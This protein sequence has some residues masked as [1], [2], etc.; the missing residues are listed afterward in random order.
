MCIFEVRLIGLI[1]Q[2]VDKSAAE[3]ADRLDKKF[4]A[5]P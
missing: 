1:V 2:V 3:S 5:T 4:F